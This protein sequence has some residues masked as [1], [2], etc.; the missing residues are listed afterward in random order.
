MSNN[1]SPIS[2]AR[3]LRREMT[4]EEKILWQKLRGRKFLGLKFLRQ[5]PIIYDRINTQPKYF[6]VDFY[7]AEKSLIIELDGKIHD[8]QKQRDSRR[9]E[10]LVGAG[11]HILRFKNEK[12]NENLSEVLNEIEDFI[13]KNS[14]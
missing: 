3:K 2:R 8:F 1:H 4:D 12:I 13:M 11:L 6:I 14:P 7:C 9:E 10:I 5:H